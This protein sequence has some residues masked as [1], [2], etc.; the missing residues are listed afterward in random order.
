MAWTLLAAAA[1]AAW[2]TAT[3]GNRHSG[4]VSRENC[5]DSTTTGAT[6]SSMV[7]IEISSRRWPTTEGSSRSS[8]ASASTTDTRTTFTRKY[9]AAA[10]RDGSSWSVVNRSE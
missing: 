10:S 8:L 6:H 3:I 1:R 5:S 2:R 4:A 9:T 7:V